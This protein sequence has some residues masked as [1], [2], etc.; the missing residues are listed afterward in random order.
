MSVSA[1]PAPPPPAAAPAPPARPAPHGLLRVTAVVAIIGVVVSLI[2]LAMMLRPVTTP[3]QDCGT[4]LGFILDGRTDVY[5]D[6]DDLPPGV[7]E[8]EA[9]ANDRNPC[10]E[11]VADQLRPAAVVF[12]SGLLV[13]LGASAVELVAR[14]I[15]WMRR[16]RAARARA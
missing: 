11:R 7:T 10:R 15:G 12:S 8:A 13:A 4:A 16:R 2:G 3:V 1:E 6:L 14:F 9:K 5:A